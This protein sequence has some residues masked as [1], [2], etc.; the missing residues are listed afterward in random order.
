M[1]PIRPAAW[2]KP[3]AIAYLP[4]VQT[5]AWPGTME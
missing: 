3:G 5:P 2:R 4:A 1:T